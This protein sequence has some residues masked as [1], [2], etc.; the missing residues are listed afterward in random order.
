[1]SSKDT[2]LEEEEGANVGQAERDGVRQEGGVES[3]C[4]DLNCA[5]LHFT[6]TVSMTHMKVKGLDTGEGTKKWHK[7]LVI[8]EGKISLSQ[9]AEFG[10]TFIKDKIKWEAKSM[11]RCSR[12]DNKKQARN[13]I[14]EC[15]AREDKVQRSSPCS[16]I[17]GLLQSSSSK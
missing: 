15:S 10:K 12:R 4:Y 9:D 11:V 8:A 14:M 6:I 1:M 2:S 16:K 13:S 17:A 5:S 7:I 3:C